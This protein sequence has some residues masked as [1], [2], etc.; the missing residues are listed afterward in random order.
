MGALFNLFSA[1][2]LSGAA[3]LN[4][5]IPLLI[6]GLVSRYTTL[7]H[8]QAPYDVLAS[9]AV[10]LILGALAAIDFLADKVPVVDHI[11]HVVGLIVH[12]I[13]GA[14]LF[15]SQ[16]NVLTNVHPAVA[17]LAG[18]IMAGSF[19]AGRMAVRPV[20]TATTAGLGNPVLS[21][22]EDVTSFTLSVLAIFVPLLAFVLLL[23]LICA[24]VWSWRRI[25]RRLGRSTP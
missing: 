21:L 2:G 12:P 25:R 24:L 23:V 22:M 8:L 18:V 1:F 11:T 3:G 16:T 20:A 19:H 4:A 17:I 9:P 6:V 14:I 10:L 7:W 5:Y 13:A 15:A